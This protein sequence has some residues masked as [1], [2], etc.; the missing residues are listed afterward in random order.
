M[1]Q[2]RQVLRRLARSPGFTAITLLTLAIGI[3]ANTAIFTVVESVLLKPLPYPSPDELVGVWHAAPAINLPE[4]NMSPANHF[5]YREQGR[6]F[7][8]LGLYHRNA[9]AVTGAGE[10]ERV[11]SL[12]VNDGFL[13]VLG[14]H[15]AL[16]RLFTRADDTPGAPAT[17]VLSHAYW[18]R[19][20]GG[21]PTA[22]GRT[23]T[24]DGAPAQVIGVLPR[25]FLFLDGED[26][27]ILQPLQLDRA[28]TQLGEFNYESVA[29]LRPGVTLAQ[30]NAD[31]AR[32]LPIVWDTFP[33][34]PGFSAELFK[35][36][37]I[38]PNVRPYKVDVVGDIG[39]VLWVLMAGI[40][41]VLLIACA[42]VA[43]LLLVR[44]EGRQHELAIRAALGASRRRLAGEL[45]FE[46]CVIGL[47]GA[48]LGLAFAAGALELL[49]SLAPSGLPR[50]AEIGIDTSVL[51]YTLGLSLGASLLFGCVPIL[52]YSAAGMG[53]M[54]TVS[55]R[56]RARNALVVVQVALAFVLL[57]GSGLMVRSFRALT[58]VEP[59]FA[60][61][62]EVQTFRLFIPEADIKDPVL[63]MR[64][65]ESIQRKL[66]ALP[67]V[68]SVGLGTSVPMDGDHWADPLFA[69]GRTYA[70]GELPTL[71]RFKFASPELLPTLGVPLVAGRLYT[72]AEIYDG[73]PV[74]VVSE[75]L[76]RE[77][78]GDP[79]SAV[80][81][82]VR[83][84]TKDVWREIVG[85]VGNM[86]ADGISQEAPRTVY[87]P[88]LTNESNSPDLDVR[89]GVT[90][91]IRTPR[92]GS[93]SL[94]T[95]VRQAVWSVDGNLPIANVRTLDQN[96]RQS[97]ARTSFTL[98]MLALAGGMA[99]LLGVVGLYGVI[100]YSVTRRTREIGIRMALGAKERQLTGLFVRQ[101]L[102]LAGV[103]VLCGVLVALGAMRLMSS[104]LF[105]VS[106]IDP[107]TYVAVAVGLAGI[108]ALAS[109]IPSRR[110]AAVDPM[111]ALRTD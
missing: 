37:N 58:Q 20:L 6:A 18:Q 65:E 95:E 60:A 25:D 33:P 93:E 100:A 84:S 82:R 15:A 31:I 48:G 4:L 27:G 13:P 104:L 69:E 88:P 78:W 49:L 85:V 2:L 1:G 53:S 34:P 99:L 43:N 24:V 94:M 77:T 68:R 29:R 103:G 73:K 106:A 101:G 26:R 111:R 40:G 83:R 14:V 81:K 92:A 56:H 110:A 52:K 89:R 17:V 30:A 109:W 90:Y 41:L 61:P 105:G 44:A 9:V 108:A 102:W 97:M 32:L 66:A 10:P 46:S 72:W 62:A 19:K 3:G 39:G 87:F 51:L 107:V 45:L 80:G 57:I 16:G 23:L 67:G 47:L 71:R 12:S 8:D 91:A 21:D 96:L 50:L 55:E 38:A 54:R 11:A 7:T 63:V 75:N 74:L 35:K 36:A 86:R 59:G 79:R 70:E 76:A 64:A 42:N 22:I 28:A 5:V 98:I